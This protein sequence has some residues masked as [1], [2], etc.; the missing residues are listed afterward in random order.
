MKIIFLKTLIALLIISLVTAVIIT[1][2]NYE[3]R[4]IAEEA[5]TETLKLNTNAN[6]DAQ[7]KEEVRQK[8][9]ARLKQEAEIKNEMLTYSF[10]L[11]DFTNNKFI[12][13]V[14][15]YSIVVPKDMKADMSISNVRAVLENNDQRI[16]IYR[17][18]IEK[19]TGASIESYYNYSNKFIDNYVDHKKEFE[20]KIRINGRDIYILQWSRNPL[21]YVENDKCYYVSVEV[22]IN[23]YEVISFFFKSNSSFDDE[24][25][26]LDI[27]RSFEVKE[28]TQEPFVKSIKQVENESWDEDAAAVYEKYFSE[29]SS[30][31]WG[32]F[33]NKAL[34]D[35]TSLLEIENKVDYRFPIILYY[36][37]FMQGEKRH[38]RVAAA[39]ENAGKQGRLVEL[40]LQTIEQYKGR[41]NMVYDVL[42]GKYDEFLK[43]YVND[44]VNSEQPVL[45]RC[46]NEMNGDW[47]VYS[48]HHTS[49]DTEIYKAFYQH[50]YKLFQEAGA[51]NII[52]VWNPNGESFPDFKWNHELCY[53]PGDEFV[54]VIGMTSYNTGTYYGS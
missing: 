42:D 30:L 11:A 4:L 17:Q 29:E 23:E 46:G 10:E 48:A 32:I 5:K 14:D 54:D 51:D 49:K 53:Y 15:G 25:K 33:E 16:E 28:R 18:E 3:Q 52:W 40:T 13:K 26:Y 1:E 45:F 31:T 44:V 41:G 37:G 12:N 24:K 7:L 19:T 34:V 22:P 27:I 21:K 39:L 6:T 43:N 8:E 38:P 9:E 35:A 50:I 20:G 47:C 2:N 36:T